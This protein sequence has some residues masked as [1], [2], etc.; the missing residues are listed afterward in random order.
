MKSSRT[1][2]PKAAKPAPA[3]TSARNAGKPGKSVR[4]GAGDPVL[5]EG[6]FSLEPVFQAARRQVPA[7]GQAEMAEFLGQFYRRLLEDEYPQHPPQ[8]W[9]AIG[10]GMLEFARKRKP[11]S[12][13][14]RVF[15]PTLND[16]GWESQYTVLQIVNDDMPFL[17]D[18]VSMALA[19]MGVGVHVLG[20]PLVRMSRDAA[21]KLQ[22]VGEGKAE[23]LMLLEVDRQVPAAMRAI[24][25]RV[26]EVLAQ[27]RAVV[28]DWG[29]MRERMQV[30]A[31]DLATRRMPVED[32][33]RRESQEF[34][35]WAAADHFTL[36][37]YREYKVV[38][39]GGG[40]VL[41]PVE[42]SGLG[43][44]RGKDT[45]S[46]R[47]VESLAAH[48]LNRAGATEALI[49]T[50]TNGR[51]RIHRKGY[52][53]YI[54]VLEFDANGVIIGEQRFLGMYTSAAYNR[55]PWE[56]PL[57]RER[58]EHVM[59]RSGLSPNSHS[60]KALRHILET[61]P[62][63]ELFQATE[64][65]L[66]RTAIGVLS[67]Q[68]RVRS[69]L[70]LRRDR[71]GRFFSALV[72]VPRER[73]NTDVR[74]RIEA[75]LKEALDSDQV[76]S[77]VVL[78]ES[79]LAQLH[80]IVRPRSGAS[81]EMD[82]A[83]L[84]RRLAHL[85]RNWQDDLREL[86]VA[87]HGEAEGLRLASTYGRALPAGY[88]EDMSPELA[89]NDVEQ[90]A[91]LAGPEDLRLS[92]HEVPR[93]G[94][95]GLRLKLYRRHRDIPLSDVLPLME[96]MGLRV[97]T[98]HP[99]RLHANLPEGGSEPIHVQDFEVEPL[100]GADHQVIG[101]E[102]FRHRVSVGG[103]DQRLGAL[104]G[105]REDARDVGGGKAQAHE[106]AGGRVILRRLPPVGGAHGADAR[107]A[108]GAVDPPAA[109]G[110]ARPPGPA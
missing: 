25:Q 73:F 11:G 34:L 33:V 74:L 40:M 32:G 60:G 76:D 51:S 108:A 45:S 39:Q 80:L 22:A 6:G 41:A 15:N 48:G 30:L 78:G 38:K 10:V 9:A 89:A 62:R 19:E 42:G 66:Y 102:T 13:N 28:A 7:A 100:A 46:P 82:T 61:L 58:F 24:E 47:P 79:P 27:V 35:R 77:S 23:S 106:A 56:I 84:E 71:Y 57:V 17:V 70:F 2:G 20:H 86:L 104:D 43:L 93:E 94:S 90:L 85:L 50:K 92:L 18:S 31:D 44:M 91:A 103:D 52:M 69:R 3:K 81:V 88:I 64:E 49:L 14:V 16:D 110:A 37:G 87:R 107:I 63:E 96:N 75:L 29:L 59:R 55:R 83:E 1:Q 8:A 95:A 68:E 101:R 54:G 109:P 98:E 5:T 12:A 21:G 67:L 26:G 53:D 105:E 4:A 65:E 72:Y 97:H 99:Y 36:Y